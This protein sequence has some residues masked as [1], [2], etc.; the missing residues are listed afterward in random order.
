MRAEGC[1][2][3]L[4]LSFTASAADLTVYCAP[5]HLQLGTQ[6]EAQVAVSGPE[7]LSAVSV[8]VNHGSITK[9]KQVGPGKF[10]ATYRPP[11]Q[12]FPRVAIVG[13]VGSTKGARVHGWTTLPLWGSAEAV[14]QTAPNANV[15]VRIGDRT[16]G[17][18]QADARGI[19]KVPV[20]VPPGV[21]TAYFGTKVLD[22]GLPRVALT[23]LVLE[24][25][26]IPADRAQTL[27]A[28]FYAVTDEGKPQAGLSLRARVS[29]GTITDFQAEAPGVYSARWSVPLGTPSQAELSVWTPADPASM[30][31]TRLKL[32]AGPPAKVVLTAV[33]GQIVAGSG[34]DVRLVAVVTDAKG[35]L[36]GGEPVFSTTLGVVGHAVEEKDGT[37]AANLLVPRGFGGASSLSVRAEV[38]GAPPAQVTVGLQ[39]GPAKLIAV[40]PERL[41][42]V[43]D[44]SSTVELRAQVLDADRNPVLGPMEATVTTGEL[45]PAPA[46]ASQGAHYVYRPPRSSRSTWTE[47]VVSSNGLSRV[48]PVELIGA[49]A[50]V[51]FGPKVGFLTNLGNAN[52]VAAALE[53]GAWWGQHFGI[54]LEGGYLFVPRDSVVAS[55]P[56]EGTR[57]SIR[58]HGVPV[59]LGVGWRAKLATTLSFQTS[60]L[61]GIVVTSS[62]IKLQGQ[63]DVKETSVVPSA[64]LTASVGYSLG[65]WTPFVEV[66]VRWLGD[67][68]GNN[69]TGSLFSVG[70]SAGCRFDLL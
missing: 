2:A 4:L 21:Q 11:E 18:I 26:E 33:P 5:S 42:L 24:S 15:S 66:G 8:T 20:V 7:D 57:V 36:T 10:V 16:Y 48:V 35:S 14:L 54:G 1:A 41:S 45:T 60:A 53:L 32:L 39:P 12:T 34:A 31:T 63:Q 51:T 25:A 9:V 22:L 27:A 65:V 52:A 44:G 19:S 40:E 23:H 28:R 38:A 68:R 13:V 29:V 6:S 37:W 17:P 50:R 62:T 59:L 61:A 49:S 58:A 55:G 64:Q 3:A 47:V 67:A 46:D 69:L 70:V 43:S 56:L 30:T